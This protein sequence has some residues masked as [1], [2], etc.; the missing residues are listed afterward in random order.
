M[1]RQ[2]IKDSIERI[3][4]MDVDWSFV[5]IV[6]TIVILIASLL[7]HIATME[8]M[9]EVAPEMR[10]RFQTEKYPLNSKELYLFVIKDTW[11]GTEYVAM[12]GYSIM[13]VPLTKEKLPMEKVK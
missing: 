12:D 10:N 11:T 5:A 4:N 7:I 3:R 6:G 2:K 13:P 9:P 1:F 8:H